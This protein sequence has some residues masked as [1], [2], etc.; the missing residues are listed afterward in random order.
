MVLGLC[1]IMIDIIIINRL[2]TL[3]FMSMV[4]VSGSASHMQPA[5]SN[6]SHGAPLTISKFRASFHQIMSSAGLSNRGYT[7]HSLRR[8]GASFAHQAGVLI[9]HIK[10]HGT[11]RSEAINAYLLS[12]P[13]FDTPVAKA[14]TGLLK[15]G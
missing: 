3:S 13:K 15:T 2:P 1:V 6:S 14:L 11:W 4:V 8:G 5:E 7:P 12:Q 9:P 10:S